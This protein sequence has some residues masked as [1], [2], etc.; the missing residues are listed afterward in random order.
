VNGL[1]TTNKIALV[2]APVGL[3]AALMTATGAFAQSPAHH[4][5]A[6]APA[7]VAAT[8]TT[9]TKPAQPA[10]VETPDAPTSQDAAGAAAETAVESTA[11]E[12]DTA[13]GHADPAGA[14]VDHQFNGEE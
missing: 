8:A 2:A 7:S 3:I 5:A 11:P 9:T 4:P 10:D 13:G 1:K 6:A 12:T 14:N